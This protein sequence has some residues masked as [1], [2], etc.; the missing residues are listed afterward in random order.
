MS[1]WGSGLPYAPTI[2]RMEQAQ[3]DRKGG[4]LPDSAFYLEHEPVVTFGRATPAEHLAAEGPHGIPTVEVPRGGLATYH[5]PGQ[6][7]GYLVVDLSKRADG[8]PADL[9]AY[10]RAIEEGLIAFLREEYALPAGI[11]EGFTGVWTHGFR[12]AGGTPAFPGR[13]LASIGVSCRRWVTA[14]GFALNIEPDMAAFRAIVPCGITDAEMT[15]VRRECELAGRPFDSKPMNELAA[16][17]HRHLALSLA[18]A[19]WCRPESK[20]A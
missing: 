9:H 4:I 18:D 13:K 11:R 19:G 5:G 15:S 7:V 14:H 8:R 3:A 17:A 2:A 12:D 10:L 16:R 6:L 20:E 1:W